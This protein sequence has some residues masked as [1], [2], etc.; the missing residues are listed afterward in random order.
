[1]TPQAPP[2]PKGRKVVLGNISYKTSGLKQRA[3]RATGSWECGQRLREGK[4][5]ATDAG[6]RSSGR[7]VP[8][9]N[10]RKVVWASTGSEE[11]RGLRRKMVAGSWAPGSGGSTWARGMVAKSYLWP[12]AGLNEPGGQIVPSWT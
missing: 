2:V 6:S 1:M 10:Q 12:G 7:D 9:S 8:L 3:G 11:P 4:P 5:R